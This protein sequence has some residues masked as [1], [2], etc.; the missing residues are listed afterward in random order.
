MENINKKLNLKE[1]VFSSLVWTTSGELIKKI[2]QFTIAVAL[3]RLLTPEDFGVIAMALV[4]NSISL[5]I[6]DGGFSHSIVQVKKIKP[7][8]L[9]SI[10]LINILIS[11]L[12]AF[13]IYI[14]RFKI[15]NFFN[16]EILSEIIPIF[17]V[18]C[19]LSGIGAVPGALLTREMRFRELTLLNIL[20]SIISG[21]IAIFLAFNNFGPWAL[22]IQS[23][24]FTLVLN[25]GY[26][27]TFNH[28]F[29]VKFNF[30]EIKEYS[31]FGKYIL[32]TSLLD[33]ILGRIYP[34]II[35]KIYDIKQVGLFSR[36]EST[37]GYPSALLTFII[38]SISF[39]L[40]CKIEEKKALKNIFF[41]VLEMAYYISIPLVAFI[42]ILS[43]PLVTII[44]GNKWADVSGYL[45][46]LVF[47]IIFR[48]PTLVNFSLIKSLGNSKSV[49]K[50][51]VIQKI[52]SIFALI[53]TFKIG[54]KALIFGQ[55]VTTFLTFITSC[56]FVFKITNINLRDQFS[57]AYKPIF[58]VSFLSF[59]IIIYLNTFSIDDVLDLFLIS[60]FSSLIYFIISNLLKIK[61][62]KYFKEQILN[63]IK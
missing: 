25:V 30:K 6:I 23:L 56:Y 38:N 42:S 54:I 3:A 24:L 9:F 53:F 45:Q 37:Q 35:G 14:L 49:F 1:K 16:V 58:A 61:S 63:K 7:E 57:N 55:V 15:S 28:K 13:T 44:Y 19:V 11:I 18:S 10:M 47:I 39:P 29:D 4:I 32:F 41:R 40:F 8:A 17:S 20:A 46:I 33:S 22:A 12:V 59:F 5:N 51:E 27:K 36:A 31:I 52:I 26:W 60:L 43:Y 34:I 50:I 48:L 62:Q 2:I 21:S